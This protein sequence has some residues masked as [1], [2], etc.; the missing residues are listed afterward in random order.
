MNWGLLNVLCFDFNRWRCVNSL[1]GSSLVWLVYTVW[2]VIPWV[3]VWLK[4]WKELKHKCKPVSWQQREGF[5]VAS[6]GFALPTTPVLYLLPEV[7]AGSSE[8]NHPTADSRTFIFLPPHCVDKKQ[9]VSAHAKL[10]WESKQRLA[11]FWCQNK[12]LSL[13]SSDDNIYSLTNFNSGIKWFIL[14]SRC[15]RVLM[16]N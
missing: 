1:V 10:A 11:L 2:V 16:G 14:S 13:L 3:N 15:I 4:I 5:Q 9:T 8:P 12:Q 7:N 6:L